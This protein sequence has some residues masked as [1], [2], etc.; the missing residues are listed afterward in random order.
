MSASCVKKR[1]EQ[2][3][4]LDAYKRLRKEGVPS[5]WEAPIMGRSVDLVYLDEGDLI[6]IEFKLTDWR[7]GLRQ[8]RDHQIGADFA[9]LCIPNR[10]PSEALRVAAKEAGVGLL[11]FSDGLGW[12][13]EIIQHALRST[14]TWSVVREQLLGRLRTSNNQRYVTS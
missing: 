6:S 2:A 13:F 8:A 14:L 1:T 4:V 5:L 11:R 9:Y 7:K 12:P 10:E 3:Y